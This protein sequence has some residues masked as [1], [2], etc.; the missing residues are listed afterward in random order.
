MSAVAVV[1]ALVGVALLAVAVVLWRRTVTLLDHECRPD[2][3]RRWQ[4]TEPVLMEP[5]DADPGDENDCAPESYMPQI[6][7]AVNKWERVDG[8]VETVDDLT[9]VR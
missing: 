8:H 1:L 6:A 4:A 9:R 2:C 7:M 5:T 3:P